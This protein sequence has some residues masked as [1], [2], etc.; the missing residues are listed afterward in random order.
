MSAVSFAEALKTA[1]LESGLSQAELARQAGLT[2]S[3]ISLLESRRRPPPTPRVIRALC[4]TLGIRARPLLEAAALERSP[5]TVRRRLERMNKERGTVQKSRDRLLTTT[6]FHLAHRPRVVEPMAEFL[7]LPLG[8]QALLGRLLGRVRKVRSLD[9]VKSRTEEILEDASTEERDAL[10]SVLPRVLTGEERAEAETRMAGASDPKETAAYA[11]V[12]VYASL[13]AHKHAVGEV[14]V[15]TTRWHGRLFFVRAAGDDAH[16]RIES[17]DLLLVDPEREPGEG[18]LVAFTHHGRDIVGIHHRKG[19]EVTIT[20]P[21]P[22]LVPVRLPARS[23]QPAG[24]VVR[25]IREM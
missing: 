10:V 21:R 15:E 1:R 23:F 16:P 22:E 17:G 13:R 4:R 2:G 25:L 24:V 6:L 8:Q 14:P 12:P 18:S 3:Y 11:A 19:E 9:E 7:D 5:P 20:F